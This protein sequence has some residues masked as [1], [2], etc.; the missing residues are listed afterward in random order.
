MRPA[1]RNLVAFG[2]RCRERA[3]AVNAGD[4]FAFAHRDPQRFDNG[5]AVHTVSGETRPVE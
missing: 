3:D 5:I 1:A 4:A 2:G